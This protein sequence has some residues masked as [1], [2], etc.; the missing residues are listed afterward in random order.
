M[1]NLNPS[2]RCGCRQNRRHSRATESLLTLIFLVRASQSARRRAGQCVTP[3]T[4]SAFG[5]GVT[6]AARIS[7]ITS[8]VST[9]FGPP[10]RG[11]SSR[12]A[13]PCP[14]YRR[15]HL[16]IVGLGAPGPLGDLRAGQPVRREQDDPGPIG[17]PGQ[18]AAV[19]RPPLQLR[20]VRIRD[21]QNA[22]AIGHEGLSRTRKRP[23]LFMLLKHLLH[24]VNGLSRA[25]DN[26]HLPGLGK[27]RSNFSDGSS[28]HDEL[29]VGLKGQRYFGKST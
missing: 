11:A 19:P 3:W 24:L 13:S 7:L 16:T 4:R 17:D 21:R 18:G 20:P 9:V 12:P 25:I 1:E 23:A 15:R 2:V 5:G 22:H 10:G 28:E 27:F 6:V 26:D 8:S 29:A 14:A